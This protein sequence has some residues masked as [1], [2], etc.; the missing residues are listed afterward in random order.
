ML[1]PTRTQ[2]TL[3]RC[4]DVPGIAS[5]MLC[6]ARDEAPRLGKNAPIASCS[7]VDMN[8]SRSDKQQSLRGGGV[9]RE[10]KRHR[11]T[12]HGGLRRSSS[13]QLRARPR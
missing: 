10:Q 7:P 11:P 3:G 12:V 4:V 13:R 8:S 6:G 2:A 1:P 9:R 5:T